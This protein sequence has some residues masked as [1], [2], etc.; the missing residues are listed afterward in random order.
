MCEGGVRGVINNVCH[1]T[2]LWLPAVQMTDAAMA[3]TSSR[4]WH[5]HRG[6]QE[7]VRCVSTTDGVSRDLVTAQTRASLSTLRTRLG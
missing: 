6:P 4:D 2:H 7:R 1:F 3:E 5:N